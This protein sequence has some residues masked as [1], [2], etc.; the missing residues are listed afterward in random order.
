MLTY[1]LGLMAILAAYRKISLFLIK[2]SLNDENKVSI[3]P[4]AEPFFL[5]G[6]K[7][8]GVLLIHGFTATPN[9]MKDLGNYLNK[10]GITVY[11]P[12]LFGHGIDP[13]YL[14]KVKFEDWL[15]DVKKSI[16]VLENCCDKIY[17]V[18]N[19]FGGNLAF[20]NVN[21]SSK[22]KGIVSLAAPFIFKN[23]N[24][25]KSLL[26]VFRQF[27]VFQKKRPTKR[28]KEIYRKAKRISYQQIPLNSL[29]ELQKI[30]NLSKKNI[31]KV[32]KR[33]LIIQSTK[34]DIVSGRS[35]DLIY[36]SIKSKDKEIFWVKD[37]IHVLIA[38][39]KKIGAFNKIYNFICG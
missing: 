19:S 26:H 12:L 35:V 27:K 37:S 22:I 6:G 30:V 36:N 32:S 38:D 4:G 23:Q 7:K 3:I 18:G 39:K 1:F 28:V 8:V 9:E 25:R 14:L 34:D 17:L 21:N 11:S 15:I 13:K 16:K 10:K 24:V 31:D 2:R 33:V 5:Q 29:L 20:L